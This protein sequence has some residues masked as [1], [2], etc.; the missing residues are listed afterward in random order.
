[1][2][3]RPWAM[4]GTR[5]PGRWIAGLA[6]LAIALAA[7]AEEVPA[8]AAPAVPPPPANGAE[9]GHLGEVVVEA[10][11]PRYVAPTRRDRIGRIW[12]PVLINDK[13]PFRLVLDTGATNSAVTAQVAAALG[14]PLTNQNNVMLRG[15]TGSRTVPTIPIDSLVVGDLELRSKRLPIVIDALGGAEGVLGT[16]GLQD[17]RIYIDFRHDKITIFRSHSERPPPGFATVPVRIEG[18]LLLVADIRIGSIRAKAI[19]DTGG[20]A[21]LANVPMREALSRRVRP[22]DIRA[23]EI[24]G[25][26][27]DVQTGDR[28]RLPALHIGDLTIRGA[29]ITVGDMFIFQHWKMTKEPAL[30]IGMDLLGLLD[31]VI[32]DYKRHELQVLERRDSRY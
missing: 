14:I 13:G 30:L 7:M 11:E 6:T 12:A 1:M 15:V 2:G 19:I 20:Q 4:R 24:T 5:G 22:E 28:V 23:D 26:T 3:D 27:L 18:G 29:N 9:A 31:T 25:A 17:K 21:T 16:E 32:I 10:P 8:P